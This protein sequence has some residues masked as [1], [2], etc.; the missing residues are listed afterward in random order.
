MN[1]HRHIRV[2]IV[3]GSAIV[4]VRLAE[5][6]GETP[7]VQLIDSVD[8]EQAALRLL[9]SSEWNVIVLDLQLREGTGFGILKALGGLRPEGTKVV[10]FTHYVSAAYR[11]RCL[12]LGADYFFDKAREF[13]RVRDVLAQ[14]AAPGSSPLH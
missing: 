8:S 14:M 3:E 11:E 9:R 5:A 13:H 10:V 7:N 4:R 2:V 1:L 12:K 6:L